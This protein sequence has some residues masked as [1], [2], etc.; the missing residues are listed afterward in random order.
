MMR[1]DQWYPALGAKD[2]MA[3]VHEQRLSHVDLF[4]VRVEVVVQ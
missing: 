2:N 3:V 4:S 1:M